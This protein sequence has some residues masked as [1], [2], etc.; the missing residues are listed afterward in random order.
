MKHRTI[1]TIKITVTPG[2]G[3]LTALYGATVKDGRE[4]SHAVYL[5]GRWIWGGGVDLSLFED[6]LQKPGDYWPFFCSYCGEPGCV[7]IFYP[8]RP[9]DFSYPGTAPRYLFRLR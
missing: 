8:G 4:Y 9:V 5:N 3:G 7:E 1:D 6:M 2:K